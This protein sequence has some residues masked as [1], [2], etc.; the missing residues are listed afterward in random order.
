MGTLPAPGYHD[1]PANQLLADE[2]VRDPRPQPISGTW[3]SGWGPASS[4]PERA[5]RRCLGRHPRNLPRREHPRADL[6]PWRQS[7][8]AALKGGLCTPHRA[9]ADHMTLKPHS[10]LHKRDPQQPMSGGSR[11]RVQAASPVAR[12]VIVPP[13]PPSTRLPSSSWACAVNGWVGSMT[14]IC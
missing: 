12:R 7:A 5:F 3:S 8:P 2:R 10:Y 9:S 11:L 13:P 14:W 1:P 6:V 4:L